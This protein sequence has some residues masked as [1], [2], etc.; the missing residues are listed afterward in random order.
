VARLRFYFGTMGSGKSTVALQI[1]HNL[2][3]RNQ[4]G[5]LLT[6]LSWDEAR[7]AIWLGASREALEVDPELD[8][9]AVARSVV[10]RHGRLDYVVADEA[11]FYEPEQ[12]EQLA[13]VVDDLA[14]DV[15]AF[16]LLTD[17]RGHLFPSTVRFLELADERNELQVESRCW[18]GSPATHNARLVNGRQVYEGDTFVIGDLDDGEAEVSYDLLCRR[19]WEDGRNLSRQP[20]LLDLRAA[21]TE[22]DPIDPPSVLSDC[23][24]E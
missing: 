21:L 2:A 20:P 10:M 17:F 3:Q 11:H 1:H 6:R 14:A 7:V 18:C 23:R 15:Y 16:G 24:T 9:H 8:L 5:L 22:P 19:H 4:R 12:A 13:R